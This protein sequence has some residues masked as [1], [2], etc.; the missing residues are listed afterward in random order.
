[1]AEDEM[2][3][4]SQ[5]LHL[6]VEGSTINTTRFRFWGVRSKL[7]GN[8]IL[9]SWYE[10]TFDLNPVATRITGYCALRQRVWDCV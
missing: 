9:F 1:M 10:I 3:C 5:G 6:A 4:V 8:I 2:R 7:K